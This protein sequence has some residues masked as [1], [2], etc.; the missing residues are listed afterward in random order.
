M[1]NF[2]NSSKVTKKD[3][4]PTIKRSS[5]LHHRHVGQRLRNVEEKVSVEDRPPLPR[6]PLRA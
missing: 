2:I 5:S 3:Q 1:H 6:R 4:L